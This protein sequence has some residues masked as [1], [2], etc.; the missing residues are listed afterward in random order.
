[1]SA[2]RAVIAATGA[3]CAVGIGTAQSWSSIR[4]GIARFGESAVRDHR[5]ELIRMAL[6]P[7]DALEPLLPAVE[8]VPFS[9]RAQRMLRLAAPALRQALTG[10]EG[11]PPALFI[12]LPQTEPS[13]PPDKSFID[14]LA[15][16]SGAAFEKGSTQVFARGRAAA[17]LALDAG[18]RHI[19][20]RRAD[21]VLV[22][23][24]DTF[25][26][27]Q[28]LGELSSEGR[29][30]GSRVMDGFIP[31]EGAAFL[32]LARP[33][34]SSQKHPSIAITGVG[35][36][37]DPGHRYSNQPARGEGLSMAIERMTGP[38]GQPPAARTTFAGF[39][40]ENFGAKEWGVARIR[41]GELFAPDMKLEHPADCFGDAGAAMGAL[42]LAVAHASLIS[43]HRAF[44]AFVWASSDREDCACAYL[45]FLA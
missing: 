35:V 42:L 19:A 18:V 21:A 43:N 29:I 27:P 37:Q 8:K 9:P 28:L 40:G 20:E 34:T 36:A 32:L 7:D 41:H 44:P 2:P 38:M 1:L 26:D 15:D 25:L 30:L 16:Q 3:V 4:T 6:L 11:A 12:G 13:G 22:G 14:A 23:G 17:L 39:N 33:G 10:F 5:F 31:G 24:V 45:D